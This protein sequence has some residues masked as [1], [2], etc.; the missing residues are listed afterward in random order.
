M[1]KDLNKI[2]LKNCSKRTKMAITEH[3]FLNIFQK[4]MPPD[5]TRAVFPS[6]LLE[7]SMLRYVKIWHS[8]LKK[9]L[10]RS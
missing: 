1:A 9:M 3:K 2:G 7:K 5:L 4:S 10:V 6:T 8:P